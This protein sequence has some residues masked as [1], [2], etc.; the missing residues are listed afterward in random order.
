M[1]WRAAQRVCCRPMVC[2]ICMVHIAATGGIRHP[3]NEAFDRSLRGQN[4]NWGVRDLEAVAGLAEEHGFAR[5]LIEE[6]PAN[7]LSL[8][9]R[10]LASN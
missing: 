8:I 10:R 7:N 3:S 1:G 5:P 9:F 4:P 6:M 2:F